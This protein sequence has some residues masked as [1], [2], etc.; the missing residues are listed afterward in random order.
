MF[1]AVCVCESRDRPPVYVARSTH[2]LRGAQRVDLSQSKRKAP[3]SGPKR[4][5][6]FADIQQSPSDSACAVDD[7]HALLAPLIT[8]DPANT[9]QALEA[10]SEDFWFG[11]DFLGRD[12]F[13]RTIHGSQI[14]LM[15]GGAV[16]AIST[17]IGLLI[18]LVAGYVRWVDAIVMRI[19]DG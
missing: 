9:H 5:N 18:G 15:V 10:A 1:S 2:S 7:D 3:V 8:G 16:A 11:T 19:M 17:F 6:T 4:S 12:V 13:A 14:S